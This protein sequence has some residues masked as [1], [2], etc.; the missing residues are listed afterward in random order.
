MAISYGTTAHCMKKRELDKIQNEAAR[1]VTGTTALVSLQSLYDEVGWESLQS[2]RSNHKRCLF[3]KM[4]NDLTPAYLSFLVPPSIS[5]TSRYNLRNADDFTTIQCRSQQY[6][7]SFLPSVVRDWNNLPQ[8]AKQINSL[9]S[10]K[11]FQARNKTK[12]PKHFY[13][14]K[15]YWQVMHTRIRTNCSALN[16]DLH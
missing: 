8:H 10:F 1:I 13:T 14:G 6:Y 12:V 15:R 4:Q 3:F 2:R 11:S 5:E 7:T 16:S 9:L